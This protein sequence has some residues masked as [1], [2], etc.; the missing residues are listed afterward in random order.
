[1]SVKKLSVIIVTYNNMD[2]ID[3]CVQS[4]YE[5]NDIGD[6]LEVI[7]VDNSDNDDLYNFVKDNY[8]NVCII[9]SDNRGFGCGNNIGFKNSCGEYLLFLNPDTKLI[10][11]IFEYAIRKFEDNEKLGL[12]GIKLLDKSLK[13]NLSFYLMDNTGFIHSQLT[14]I[15]NHL[16]IFIDG[17]MFTSG[18]NLFVKRTAF[19]YSGLF[20]EAIFLYHEES[21]LIKR[22]RIL[23]Y[24]TSFYSEKSLIHLEGNST[25]ESDF[26]LKERLKSAKY[27]YDKYGISF[28]KNLKKE[29]RYDT[30]KLFYMNISSNFGRL[31]I[32]QRQINIKK[33]YLT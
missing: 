2:V 25:V 19:F 26:A 24:V 8:N 22:I 33:D 15:C 12:F 5:Y 29:L 9:K 17:K 3:E 4:I 18:A 31:N 11:P 30:L 32:L 20:D 21:D 1:M 27:Y 23:G 7:I 10:M 16:N 13:A 6:F 14:K 28:E